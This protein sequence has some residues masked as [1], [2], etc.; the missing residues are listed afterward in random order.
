MSSKL[1]EF[2]KR[3]PAAVNAYLACK[4]IAYSLFPPPIHE[5]TVAC[6]L[7]RQTEPVPSEPVSQNFDTYIQYPPHVF[8]TFPEKDAL[9]RDALKAYSSVSVTDE[10]SGL[11]TDPNRVLIL[12]QLMQASN[13]LPEGDYIE[14]GSHRGFSLRVIYKFMDPCRDLYSL[15]TFEGFD[16]RDIAVERTKYDSQWTAGSF[17]PTSVDNVA[18]YVGD[19]SWPKNLKIVKGWF[20]ESFKGFENIRWRFVHIDFDLYNPIKSALEALWD[21]LLPGGIILIHDYGCYGF[22]G[23]RQ[24][25]D[26]FC[27]RIGH[28]PIELSDRWSSA[29]LR[30]PL[31]GALR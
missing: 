16:D 29:A 27:K 14:L 7:E 6:S 15:D 3:V 12:F 19:G 10:P 31:D 26:E 25:V 20:P 2:V 9:L 11:Y 21:P 24:A 28:L 1:R 5:N 8:Y 22:P 23:V 17:A 18:R 13:T 30:K 4:K